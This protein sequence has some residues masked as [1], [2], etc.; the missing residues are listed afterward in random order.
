MQLSQIFQLMEI[1][2]QFKDVVISTTKHT[3]QLDKEKFI[4]RHVI[5]DTIFDNVD[6]SIKMP[7][8]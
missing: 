3:E 7:M 5:E 8:K 6:P 2:E 4:Q 1:P